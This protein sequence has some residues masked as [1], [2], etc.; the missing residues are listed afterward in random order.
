M[1]DTTIESIM[2]DLI[3]LDIDASYAYTEAL[4][5]IQEKDIHEKMQGFKHDHERHITDL[6]ALL[7]KL[8]GEPIKH[9]QD[10]KGY[11]IE[12][13]T[14][15]RSITGTEGALKAMIMNEALT[16]KKYHD[17][18]EYTGFT[19]EVRALIRANYEDEKKHKAYIES[20]VSEIAAK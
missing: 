13:M 18:L 2:N 4:K 16:N 3:Q 8:G 20:K 7:K 6:T 19:E 9:T 12:G 15:L 17:A 10:I 1:F 5:A 11:V 14:A